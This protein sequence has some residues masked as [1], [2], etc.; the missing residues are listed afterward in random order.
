MSPSEAP[1]ITNPYRL[2]SAPSSSSTSLVA[3]MKRLAPV[4][5][6]QR[7]S[8]VLAFVA[9]MAASGTGL[10]APVI[11]GRTVDRYIGS[12]DFAGVLR[13]AGLLLL[14]YLVGFVATYVQAQQMGGVGRRVLFNL[15]NRLFTKLQELPLDFFQQNKAGDLI[16]R[17]NNDTD[18]LNQ[19]FS[20]ALV[21]LAA[22]LFLM[23]G[24]VVFLVTLNVRLGLAAL[25]PAAVA[26]A[27]TRANGSRVKNRNTESLQARVGMRGEIN[28]SMRNFRV[29]L[30]FNRIDYF[31]QQFDAA[32]QRNYAAAVRAGIVNT[33]F[34][35]LY[36]LAM[37]LAQIVVLAYGFRLITDGAFT[38]GLLIGF[39]LF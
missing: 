19:F 9:T 10:I 18:K 23:A 31:K 35:P 17:I 1:A 29:I 11:I 4:L 2:S 15:R 5:A 33:M 6:D 14:A 8:M 16:S 26:L 20:Q 24:A 38:V 12:G 22:N 30:A 39:L 36:G 34:V 7:R 13:S 27:F 32:N 28:E 21:Q 25:A 3:A 37:I